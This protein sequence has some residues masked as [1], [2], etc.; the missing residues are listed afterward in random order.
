MGKTFY[1]QIEVQFIYAKCLFIPKRYSVLTSQNF[2]CISV[3]HLCFYVI[4]TS[5]P[6]I[7]Y[8]IILI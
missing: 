4:S 5:F 1:M 2:N 3:D 6:L 8:F 7:F